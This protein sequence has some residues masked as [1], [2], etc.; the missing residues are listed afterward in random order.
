MPTRLG[1]TVTALAA[2]VLLATVAG[3][4][5]T[6]DSGAQG[7]RSEPPGG[8]STSGTPPTGTPSPSSTP[9]PDPVVFSP[10]VEDGARKVAVDTLV[11]VK[12]SSGTLR[13]VKMTY[14]Y[15]DRQGRAKKGSVAG[16]LNKAKT[17][18]TADDRLEPAATYTLSMSGRNI[19]NQVA[20]KKTHFSTQNLSLAEQTFPTLY[21]LRGM[22]VGIGMP[23]VLTFD[24]PVKN[25]REFEKNLKVTSSPAQPGSWRWY[26]DTQVR[27]RPKNYWKPGT[28]IRVN[29]DVNGVNAGAG[30]YGQNSTTTSFTVGRSFKI[31]VNLRSDVA[32]V[33]KSG[34]KV[35]TIYVS[36]GKPGW[37]TRSGIKLIMAKEYNKKMTNEAIGAKE[38][39]TLI[40][41]H[42]LRITNSGEFLHSAPWNTAHFGRR[43][44]SHG[45]TGMSNGNAAWLYTH[46]LIG[47][48]VITT[49]SSRGMED[50]NG[51]SDWNVSWS[52]YKKGSAL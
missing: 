6:R 44:A 33:Y 41:R 3:C 15:T 24:V 35:R 38:D 30:I 50:G 40:A 5:I 4:G 45:C 42:A 46:T 49:G 52:R 7:N 26:S 22:K 8:P 32:T 2:T 20:T 39:Y 1:R 43:N 21:P 48:P 12:A 13:K 31:R 29:A 18:W 16:V 19:A 28:K 34:R 14:A 9:T 23:V 27:Y 51:Y 10:N 11:K 36:G 17:A 25:K 37:Q 47:D